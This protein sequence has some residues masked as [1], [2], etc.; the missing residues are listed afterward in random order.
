[1]RCLRWVALMNVQRGEVILTLLMIMWEGELWIILEG[2]HLIWVLPVLDVMCQKGEEWWD[3]KMKCQS[4]PQGME[5]LGHRPCPQLQD[6]LSFK[7]LII[8]WVAGVLGL[9][10]IPTNMNSRSEG[11]LQKIIDQG[12]GHQTVFLVTDSRIHLALFKQ[13]QMKA[14]YR[15]LFSLGVS[16]LISQRNMMELQTG[17]ITWNTLKL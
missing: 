1:M 10:V 8:C 3:L 5:V 9:W 6:T 16:N 17:Q 14:Y 4:F 13:L 2:V 12:L 7:V 15:G 11:Y